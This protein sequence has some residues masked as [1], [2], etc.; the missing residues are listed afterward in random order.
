M[1]ERNLSE[2]ESPEFIDRIF[3][4]DMRRMNFMRGGLFIFWGTLSAVTALLEYGLFRWT[5][6][7]RVLW[8]WV[9]VF[10]CGYLL[11]VRNTRRQAIVRTGFDNLLIPVWGFPAMLS[12]CA[13]AY[14]VIQPENTMNPVGVMQLLLG[15]ALIVTS[16]FY[17]GKGS[18]QSGSYT[19]LLILALFEIIFAFNYTFRRPFDLTGGTW[20]LETA[21][22]SI[23]LVLLPGFILRH[24]TRRQ[25][26][27]N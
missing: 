23:L 25:C 17:R 8:S 16:G 11:T 14:A 22:H 18:G 27:K 12:V 3:D 26:S 5:G 19:A 1:D 4:P 24:I 7:V 13:V 21:L 2:R 20:I 6:D 10:I 9:A 15:T